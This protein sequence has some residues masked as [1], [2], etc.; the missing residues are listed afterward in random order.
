MSP[1]GDT[2]EMDRRNRET[3][4]RGLELADLQ[5]HWG[6]AYAITFEAGQYCARRRDTRALVRCGTAAA[7]H[8]EISIDYRAMPVPRRP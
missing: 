4:R 6:S 5:H 8:E 3:A 7:L 2:R 1:D